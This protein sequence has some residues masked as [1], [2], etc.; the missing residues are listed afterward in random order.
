MNNKAGNIANVY[1]ANSFHRCTAILSQS[2]CNFSIVKLICNGYFKT[3]IRRYSNSS[4]SFQ[5]S[6]LQLSGD[7][8]PNPRPN[9]E[10]T[11]ST[12]H[13]CFDLK[14]KGLKIR[15]LNVRSLPGHFEEIRAPMHI[16]K[17]DMFAMNETW[18]NQT[19]SDP[20]LAIDGYSLHRCDRVASKREG[21]AIYTKDLLV[22]R[23]IELLD[24]ETNAEYVCLE[25]KQHRAGP[26]FYLLCFIALLIH[27]WRHMI[28]FQICWTLHRVIAT[29]LS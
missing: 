3:R 17:F 11:Q 29:I 14:K 16:D 5:S 13:P 9:D 4:S 2:N 20:E 15:H 26:K 25:I 24:K 8:S 7:V 18:L 1:T 21:T 6:R 23:R 27:Q 22:C 10:I 19:W 28:I 12:D